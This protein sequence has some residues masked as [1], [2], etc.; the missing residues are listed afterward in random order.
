MFQPKTT[1]LSTDAK[2]PTAAEGGGGCVTQ[3][4]VNFGGGGRRGRERTD[5]HCQGTALEGRS[6]MIGSWHG[7]GWGRR[8]RLHR[9]TG[10]GGVG[11]Q[12]LL[13]R[14]AGSRAEGQTDP[15]HIAPNA[16][17]PRARL[18]GLEGGGLAAIASS[19]LGRSP[20]LK[21]RLTSS[22]CPPILN[23]HRCTGTASSPPNLPIHACTA[24]ATTGR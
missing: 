21:H 8:S 17:S 22:A 20:A 18:V 2:F 9:G 14:P 11:L 24:P 3:E 12:P 15:R 4:G 23:S 10:G 7:V 16:H 6:R 19:Q 5:G 13:A 1:E